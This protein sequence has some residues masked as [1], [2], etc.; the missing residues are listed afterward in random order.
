VNRNRQEA[1]SVD[2]LLLGIAV[3]LKP[4][5]PYYQNIWK[6]YLSIV[7]EIEIQQMVNA[8]AITIFSG[9]PAITS[10]NYQNFNNSYA[11]PTITPYYTSS[12]LLSVSF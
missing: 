6:K 8:A 5:S 1:N 10:V 11:P 9:A 4:F 3:S 7:S 12:E 2:S